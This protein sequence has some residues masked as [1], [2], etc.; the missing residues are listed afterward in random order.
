ME[1]VLVFPTK[2]LEEVNCPNG[3]IENP[4]KYLRCILYDDNLTFVDRDLAEQDTNLQQIIP[5]CVL[6]WNGE[7]FTYERTKKSGENRL[8]NL[9]SLGIGGHV[10]PVD[11]D[12]SD[13]T[14]LLIKGFLV[15][16]IYTNAFYRELNEEVEI[17][18]SFQNTI[19]GCIR[20]TSNDVGR[21]HFG[22]IHR[23]TLKEKNV[24]TVDPA[25][26]NGVFRGIVEVKRDIE[27][28]ESWSKLVIRYGL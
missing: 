7:V 27:K 15:P 20:D 6:R 28:F 13:N 2:L 23:L 11:S 26:T 17:L 5:Y 22:I 16:Q 10:N 1:Q 21:V 3:Y 25:L 18:S 12:S 8:H 9:L 24:K 14:E 4:S 19:I